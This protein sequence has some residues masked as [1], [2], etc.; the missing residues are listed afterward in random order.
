MKATVN[1][2]LF[3]VNYDHR[4]QSFTVGD[5][6]VT[7]DILALDGQHFHILKNNKSYRAEVIEKNT[8]AKK[9][10]L[11]INGEVY[12]VALTDA[13]DELLDK[14]GFDK[15]IANKPLDIKAPMPGLV[16]TILV[17]EGQE[18]KAGDSVV[19]L[20]A[21]KMENV[22]KCTADTTVKGIKIKTGQTVE[23]NQLLVTL[24]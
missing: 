2:Q 17:T 15:V 7:L 16:K 19:I 23:K 21:M 4:K 9:V 18:L 14:L 24:I 10:V 13:L 11:K 12:S 3:E 1:Q 20:E 8:G 5:A 22:L 6:P